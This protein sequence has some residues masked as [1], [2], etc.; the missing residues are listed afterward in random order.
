[1]LAINLLLFQQ[2]VMHAVNPD[3]E[4][5]AQLTR[6][7]IELRGQLMAQAEEAGIKIGRGSGC[8]NKNGRGARW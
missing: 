6:E 3:P 5:A 2:A 1:L 8:G 4:Q 7:M